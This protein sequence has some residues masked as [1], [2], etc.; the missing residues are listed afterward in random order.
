MSLSEALFEEKWTR[1][2]DAS[3]DLALV[4][5]GHDRGVSGIIYVNDS[6]TV[7]SIP[8]HTDKDRVN[9]SLR[10]MSRRLRITTQAHQVLLRKVS[11]I[12]GAI[13]LGPDGSIL[14][15]GC[16]ICDPT[17]SILARAGID[18]PKRFPGARST[19][20]WNAS[21]HG[22]AIKVSED[23]PITVFKQG[24]MILQV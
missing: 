7:E 5:L 9:R 8:D 13:V 23:G 15:A 24:E 16:M 18:K 6:I 17:D 3:D 1:A 11:A 14:D 4:G 20:A 21:L 10:L 19:A 12:D 22:I 2:L